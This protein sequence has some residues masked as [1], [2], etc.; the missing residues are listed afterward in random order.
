MTLPDGVGPHEGQEFDLMRKGRKNVALFYD[1]EPEG[2]NDF[3]IE[4]FCLLQFPHHVFQGEITFSRIVFRC[5]FDEDALRLKTI[6]T[7]GSTEID[8]RREHEI[9]KILS[10]STSEV[11]AYLAHVGR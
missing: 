2:L 4:G 8:R 3:L 5:G 9:G 7:D 1:F 6:I 10:Y 11:E